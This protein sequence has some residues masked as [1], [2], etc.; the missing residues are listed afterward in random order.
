MFTTDRAPANG[1]SI[2][3]VVNLPGCASL[4]GSANSPYREVGSK[5]SQA[6]SVAG[7]ILS[8]Y[9]KLAEGPYLRASRFTPLSLTAQFRTLR[10]RTGLLKAPFQNN[11][12]KE[13]FSATPALLQIEL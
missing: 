9:L 7:W 3:S 10:G 11:Y 5:W 1:C 4:S 8:P 13:E 2:V 12:Q 6:Y